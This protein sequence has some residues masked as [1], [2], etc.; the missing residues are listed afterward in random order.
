MLKQFFSI[1]F[2]AFFLIGFS[3]ENELL[4]KIEKFDLPKPS[5]LFGT[6]H[7][8]SKEAFNFSDE[9]FQAIDSCETFALELHPDSMITSIFGVMFNEKE[10]FELD[11]SLFK[12]LLS[13]D[14]YEI[15]N[16][17]FKEKTGKN[18]NQVENKSPFVLEQIIGPDYSKDNDEETFVD[19]H[20]YGIA[21]T[22]GKKI[23]G[24]ENL[25]TQMAL[26]INAREEEKTKILKK[27]CY[28]DNEKMI[29]VRN[30]MVEIYSRG[31][32]AGIDK[33]MGE[34]LKDS[35]MIGRNI[36][37]ANTI[38]GVICQNKT[39]FSA[40]GAG[41]LIGENSVINLLRKKGYTVTLVPATFSH[42]PEQYSI[43]PKAFDWYVFSDSKLGYSVEFPA[44]P[45]DL[46]ING[47][48]KI[49]M[50][51]DILNKLA[52]SSMAMDLSVLPKEKKEN[53]L[54]LMIESQKN[55]PTTKILKT[56]ELN[57]NGIDFFE[58]FLVREE[59]KYYLMRFCVSPE[60]SFLLTI[61]IGNKKIVKNKSV[62]RFFESIKFIEKEKDTTI[63]HKPWIVDTDSV[64]AFRIST[65]VEVKVMDRIVP[66][67][68]DE[69]GESVT[70]KMKMATDLSSKAVYIYAYNDLY[71]G[72]VL[73]NGKDKF[74]AM[75]SELKLKGE[76]VSSIDTV[77]KNG[78]EGRAFDINLSDTYF[79]KVQLYIRGNRVYKILKQNITPNSVEMETDSYF[80]SIEFLPFQTPE[81]K[82]MFF[83]DSTFS[84]SLYSESKRDT[85]SVLDLSSHFSEMQICAAKDPTSGGVIIFEYFPWKKYYSIQK[86]DSIYDDYGKRLEDYKDTIIEQ[87]HYLINNESAKRYV[88]QDKTTEAT[89]E[90]LVL[91][92]NYGLFQWDLSFDDQE[93]K[94]HFYSTV[95]P[96]IQYHKESGFNVFESKN[97]SVFADLQSTDSTI[98]NEALEA[99]VYCD[100]YQ[101]DIPLFFQALIKNFNKDATEE[102]V[103]SQL[104][105]NLHQIQ[106]SASV[107][108]LYDIYTSHTTDAMKKNILYAFQQMEL[109]YAH[110]KYFDAFLNNPPSDHLLDYK[111]NAMLSDSLAFIAAHYPYFLSLIAKPN[112]RKEILKWSNR[113]L[114]GEAEGVDS[115]IVRSHFDELTK[116]V[117]MDIDTFIQQTNLPDNP[118]YY[119]SKIYSYLLLMELFS[120]DKSKLLADY[121]SQKI[122]KS[123]GEDF[124]KADALNTRIRLNLDV[125]KKQIKF[126]LE[127]IYHRFSLLETCF[128]TEHTGLLPKKYRVESELA[129]AKLFEYLLEEDEPSSLELLD[130]IQDNSEIIYVFKIN[131]EYLD[132][133]GKTIKSSYIGLSG[134]YRQTQ[135]INVD[136]LKAHSSWIDYNPDWKSNIKNSI[137][138]YRVY[139][140]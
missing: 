34:S 85:V 8:Q 61:A 134:G 106:D 71:M 16:K 89:K 129:K 79:C 80:D 40:V 123:N 137:E 51:M 23:I 7:V 120:T 18:L 59:D 118:Y 15:L 119:Q 2:L 132:D 56:R 24:L 11:D 44:P 58:L 90:Y 108:L 97:L 69:N 98:V 25:E 42:V 117:Q 140:Y 57:V 136:N 43:D 4:W 87:S 104:I 68:Y 54:E 115:N 5:Y 99:L 73:S 3:Q 94:K 135:K 78:V 88:I 113:I 39:L 84:L 91:I 49:K 35:I 27:L 6:M 26:F 83:K 38:D 45:A 124:L 52:Y 66:N 96:S 28:L 128:T 65:P 31:D 12:E 110:Q 72:Y 121:L 114:Q 77:W 122:I 37:M 62:E 130:T 70:V 50:S 102:K 138:D 32:L 93:L 109:E 46:K 103:K 47:I 126:Y 139:G 10:K 82:N 131:Y 30:E 67:P 92:N 53:I 20:L 125:D 14:E 55:I 13:T 74:D 22:L 105:R 116:Y 95:L 100:F 1:A 36:V 48:L 21:G 101:K 76:I 29:E 33:L 127:N 60:N 81:L 63:V 86:I 41:H 19:A 133:D 107:D 64:G 9:V 75:I 17:K 111:V 112:Y